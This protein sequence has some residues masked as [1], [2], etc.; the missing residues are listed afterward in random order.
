MKTTN[1][2]KPTRQSRLLKLFEIAES[3]QG[4]FTAKQA[5]EAGFSSTNHP[6]YVKQGVWVKEER[7]IYRLKQY[8]NTDRMDLILY[9]LWSRDR[10]DRPQGVYSH[11]TAL[12]IHELSDVMPSKLYMTV[13][14]GF[15]KSAKTP[16][17]LSLVYDLIDPAEIENRHGYRVTKP[18]RAILDLIKANQT[19]PEFIEQALLE[20]VSR[21]LVTIQELRSEQIPDNLRRSVEHQLTRPKKAMGA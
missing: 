12:T 20:G 6:Y 9:S 19:S 14:P 11:E 3:Q 21:G 15:R 8:P 7:G 18:F 1:S 16:K 2:K 17:G 5:Q 4:F 10:K 13:P